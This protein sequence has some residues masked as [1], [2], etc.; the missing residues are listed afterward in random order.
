MDNSKVLFF[1]FV[2][3]VCFIITF[4]VKNRPRYFLF[5]LVL[6]APLPVGLIFRH[7]NGI[8]FMDVPLFLLLIYRLLS[9]RKFRLYF[10]IPA[11]GMIVWN[12]LSL[13]VAVRMDVA[14]SELTRLIRAY[15]AFLCVVNFTKSKKDIDTVLIALLV[16]L[17]LQGTIGYFQWHYGSLGLTFLGEAHFGWR[18]RGLFLHPSF[19]GNY[20]IMLIPIV[21]RLFVFYKPEKKY[22]TVLYGILITISMAALYGSY[23]RGPWIAF[24]GAIIIMALFTLFQIRFYPKIVSATAFL[25]FMGTILVINYTPIIIT[26]FTDKY[27]KSSTDVRMPLNKVALRMIKDNLVFGTGLGNYELTSYEYVDSEDVTE[28]IP[29]EQLTQMVH[30]SYLLIAA[31]VGVPGFIFFTWVLFSIFKTGWRVIRI[32]NSLISNLGLGILTSFLAILISFLASPDYREHQIMMF[33]WIFAGYLVA[34]SLVR[35]KPKKEMFQIQQPQYTL[36]N[37]P[38]QLNV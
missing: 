21:L 33:F 5:L 10:A 14:F 17:A 16:G 13:F 1:L 23:A 35:P 28:Q 19:F 22:Y 36:N 18:A 27:R 9:N 6:F 38:M 31:E 34:L 20:L 25:V 30:N 24:A 2:A 4:L 32:R 8:Y 7:F 11:I 15:L 3:A 37:K 12:F 29:F 26:Q